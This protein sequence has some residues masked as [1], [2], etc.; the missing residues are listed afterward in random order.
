[1]VTVLPSVKLSVSAEELEIYSGN[2]KY[3]LYFSDSHK[4]FSYGL[5]FIPLKKYEMKK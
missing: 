2:I 1:M 3:K 4:E 5:K